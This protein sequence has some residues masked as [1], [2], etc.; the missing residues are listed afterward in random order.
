VQPDHGSMLRYRAPLPSTNM[1]FFRLDDAS[2]GARRQNLP[3]P[4][5]HLSA[6]RA[7][8][9]Q[10]PKIFTY[11]RPGVSIIRYNGRM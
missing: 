1:H 3:L 5:I 2:P 4:S 7:A 9:S 8:K 6:Y 11:N 10:C